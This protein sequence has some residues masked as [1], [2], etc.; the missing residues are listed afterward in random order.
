MKSVVRITGYSRKFMAISF[1]K[2]VRQATGEGL[3]PAKNRLD[4]LL[5]GETIELEFQDTEAA[6]AFVHSLAEIGG[7]ADVSSL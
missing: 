5:T 2:L 1:V 7:I 6:Q 4:R 3:A